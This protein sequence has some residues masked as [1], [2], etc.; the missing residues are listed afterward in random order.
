MSKI[1]V[2]DDEAPI[3]HLLDIFCRSE[4]H[5]VEIAC[6]GLEAAY[7]IQRERYDL[8][9]TDMTM[10]PIPGEELIACVRLISPETRILALSGWSEEDT[11]TQAETA[12]ADL[13]MSKP[14]TRDE[15]TAALRHFCLRSEATTNKRTAD[16]PCAAAA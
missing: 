3:R 12:G 15:F 13:Y 16:T 11:R 6:D 10:E 4:G 1:L 8:I 9:V 7:K 14:F 5:Q 2:V